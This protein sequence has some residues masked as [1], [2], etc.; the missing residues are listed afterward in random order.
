MSD[1][2]ADNE[3]VRMA[4]EIA[5]FFMPYPHDEA[6]ADIAQH[7]VDFW[8]PRMRRAMAEIVAAGGEGLSPLAREGVD[9]ALRPA[10]A[11]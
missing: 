2:E 1:S 3:L 7:I 9:V 8:D 4:N 5:M 10:P 11:G 6:V